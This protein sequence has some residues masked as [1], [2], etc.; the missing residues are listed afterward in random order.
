MQLWGAVQVLQQVFGSS[1]LFYRGG[2]TIPFFDL[3]A[4][5]LGIQPV[6]FGFG[7]PSD[8]IHAPNER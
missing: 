7:L 4:S 6:S 8:N 1:V 2:W 3:C 5:H